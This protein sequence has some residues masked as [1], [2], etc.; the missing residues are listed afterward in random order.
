MDPMRKISIRSAFNMKES[1]RQR[2]PDSRVHPH[3]S[4]YHISLYSPCLA[5]IHE[6]IAFT[7]AVGDNVVICVSS[8]SMSVTS[9]VVTS[10]FGFQ[11]GQEFR[12]TLMCD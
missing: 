6:S 7:T 4:V 12:M 9:G 1:A 2:R 3:R 10:V 8:C 11:R 5:V